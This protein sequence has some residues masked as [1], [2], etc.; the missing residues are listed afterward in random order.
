VE[1]N[2]ADMFEA[3]VDLVPDRTACVIVGDGRRTY[4]ELEDRVNRM[5]HHL[6]SA[7]VA[8]GDHVGIYAY[9]GVEWVETLLAVYKIR[10]VPININYRYVEA[11]L[12]YLC[13]NADLVALVA[14]Q[15]FAPR[16]AAIRDHLP[17]LTHVVIAADESGA[18]TEGLEFTDYETA[19]AAASAGGRRRRSRR[20]WTVSARRASSNGFTR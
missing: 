3:I 11:E 12:E 2:F 10:A 8:P 4:A 20:R 14:L 19:L 18:S 15:E 7:G 16:I 17:K 6:A 5:A 1:T 13:K 9:N